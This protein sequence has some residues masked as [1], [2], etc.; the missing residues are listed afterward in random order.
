MASGECGS[1]ARMRDK[2]GGGMQYSVEPLCMSTTN[3][4]SVDVKGVET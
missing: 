2:A 3:I 1:W 4:S